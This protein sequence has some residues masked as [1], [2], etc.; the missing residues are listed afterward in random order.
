MLL[1]ALVPL[2][3]TL[4]SAAP[5][6]PSPN[7][8]LLDN[9]YNLDDIDISAFLDVTI[10]QPDDTYLTAISGGV[11]KPSSANAPSYIRMTRKG[12]MHNT[13]ESNDQ[14]QDLSASESPPGETGPLLTSS[15]RPLVLCSTPQSSDS[16]EIVTTHSPPDL[17][18]ECLRFSR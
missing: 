10:D 3:H 13:M 14:D 16:S 17:D 6:S 15:P 4:R 18:M 5:P 7:Q 8:G 1:V 12:D 2:M 11:A 9:P